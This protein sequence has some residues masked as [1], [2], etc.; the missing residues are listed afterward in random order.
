VPKTRRSTAK[1]G[2]ARQELI[3]LEKE[4][5]RAIS[6]TI[7]RS[8]RLPIRKISTEFALREVVNKQ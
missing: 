8:L 7:R 4:N 1:S 5:A 6:Y 2:D 3:N